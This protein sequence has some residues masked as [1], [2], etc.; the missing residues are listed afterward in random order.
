M[1][2]QESETIKKEDTLGAISIGE[3]AKKRGVKY[4][5]ANWDTIDNKG[6]KITIGETMC[7]W[8]RSAYVCGRGADLSKG[9]ASACVRRRGG[10]PVCADAVSIMQAQANII[11]ASE[12]DFG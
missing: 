1:E 9:R 7:V 11:Y 6:E 2:F 8:G 12:N 4:E 10:V 5:V 3:F